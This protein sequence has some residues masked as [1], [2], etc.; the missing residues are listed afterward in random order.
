MNN[1]IKYPTTLTGQ[2]VHLIS[3]ERMRFDGVI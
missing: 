3:P 2:T 1:C